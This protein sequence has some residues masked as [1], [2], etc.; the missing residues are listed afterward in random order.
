LVKNKVI[1]G[2]YHIVNLVNKQTNK[3]APA[4]PIVMQL[5]VLEDTIISIQTALKGQ[6]D[7]LLCSY[8]HISTNSILCRGVVQGAL[9]TLI[10][11]ISSYSA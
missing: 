4:T 1:E 2:G 7:D 9:H 10:P 11:N 8:Y 6:T 3:K 5:A